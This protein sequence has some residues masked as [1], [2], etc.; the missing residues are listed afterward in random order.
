MKKLLF[1]LTLT[2]VVSCGKNEETDFR[3]KNESEIVAY[4]EANNL[5][6]EKSAS[7]LYYVINEEGDGVRPTATSEVTVA[8]KGY[9]TNGQVFDQSPSEG[10]S[11]PLQRVI[12]GWTEG[13]QY[14]KEGGSGMLLVPSHLGYGSQDYSSIPGGSVLVFEV[15]L[16]S[17]D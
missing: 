11:F 9:F 16:I 3:V 15:H 6:A 14:F 12:S 2:L 17:V 13:I 1:V 7:G 5:Q 8:Y 4:L 10:I